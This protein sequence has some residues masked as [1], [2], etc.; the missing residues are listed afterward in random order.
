MN[1]IKQNKITFTLIL[2]AITIIFSSL[3]ILS[4]PVLFNY[5]SKV[6]IIEN[7]F[8]KNFKLYLNSSGIISYKPFPKPHLLV[9]NA[10][11]DLNQF[12]E[13][14]G[15]IKTKNLKIFI[16]LRDIYLRSFKNFVST[17]ISNT[18]IDLKFDNFKEIRNHLYQNVNKT[19]FI[20]NCKIFLRNKKNEVILISPVKKIIY[21]I[22]NKTKVKNFNI[23]GEVFGLNFKSKWER[24]YTKPKESL[25]SINILYPKI[26]IEN[27]LKFEKNNK[28]SGKSQIN[29][30]QDKLEYN[31]QFN[32]KKIKIYSPNNEKINFNIDSNIELRPFYFNGSLMI[33]NKRVE[34]I[35][36]NFLLYLISY[37]ENYLGNLNGLLKIKFD[38]L[39]NKLIKMGEIKLTV[40]EKK[41][42]IKEAKFELN[43][44][45]YVNSTISFKE[46][47]DKKKFITKNQLI[48][49]NYIEF[50]KIF[51]IGSNKV[52]N[53]KQIHFDLE[54]EYDQTDFIIKNVK[55]YD[56]ERNL[57]SNDIFLIKNIQN[58]RSY[59]RELIN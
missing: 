44:I 48:I 2:T 7:N 1:K 4:L 6:T 16:S 39:N 57:K 45:G 27:R 12:Q 11:I 28:F 14:S 19:I 41:I 30:R 38:D 17:E 33:K 18:N 21:K 54:K 51:Q 58:L 56:G 15:L 31:F 42:N 10:I 46:D 26:E 20:N 49:E 29:Y 3:T 24:D 52:K 13:K 36:D 32:N 50:A 40:N 43:K 47:E 53:I 59:I 5:K 9:E 34:K 25:H 22:N 23:N 55:I 8:Y 37:N 35:I